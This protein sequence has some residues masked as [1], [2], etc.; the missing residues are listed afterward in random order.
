MKCA[1]FNTLDPG[2]LEFIIN[3]TKPMSLKISQKLIKEG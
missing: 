3:N 1:L 2:K